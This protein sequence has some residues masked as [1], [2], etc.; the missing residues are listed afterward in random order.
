MAAPVSCVACRELPEEGILSR[1]LFFSPA[2]DLTTMASSTPTTT[3]PWTATRRPVFPALGLQPPP[4]RGD[5]GEAYGP[6]EAARWLAVSRFSSAILQLCQ[7]IAVSA[8]RHMAWAT[9]ILRVIW[10]SHTAVAERERA[11]L[12]QGPLAPDGLFGPRFSEVLAHQQSVRENRSRFG[13][14]LTRSSHQQAGR[15]RG[16]GRF[17]DSSPGAAA[18]AADWVAVG[19]R[20]HMA[21][22]SPASKKRRP[23]EPLVARARGY[24]RLYRSPSSPHYSVEAVGAEEYGLFLD[25]LPQLSARPLSD[26][27]ACWQER[28][29]TAL[30]TMRLLGLMAAAHPVVPLGLLFMRRLQRWFARQRCRVPPPAWVEYPVCLNSSYFIKLLDR[31]LSKAD[32]S[33]LE[34]MEVKKEMDDE[35]CGKPEGKAEELHGHTFSWM[36]GNENPYDV[37]CR[38]AGTIYESLQTSDAFKEMASKNQDKELVILRPNKKA[39]NSNFPCHKMTEGDT[40]TIK[41]IK[42]NS[43]RKIPTTPTSSKEKK[44]NE[45]ELVT[46]GIRTTGGKNLSRTN[47]MNNVGLGM[48]VDEISVCGYKGQTVREALK[49]DGRL[50]DT[51]LQNNHFLEETEVNKRTEMSS[52]I[53]FLDGRCFKIATTRKSVGTGKHD[54]PKEATSSKNA[55]SDIPTPNQPTPNTSLQ[56]TPNTIHQPTPSTSHQPTPTKSDQLNLEEIANLLRS[57]FPDLSKR[58]KKR[59]GAE[60]PDV[61]QLFSQEFGKNIAFCKK[62]KTMRKFLDLGDS[63]CQVR[64]NGNEIGSGFLLFGKYI[65]TNAHVVLDEEKINLRENLTVIFAYEDLIAN[66]SLPATVEAWTY[67]VDKDNYKEDWA[68]LEV[69]GDLNTLPKI[70]QPLLEHFGFVKKGGQICIIGHPEGKVKMIDPCCTVTREEF[71]K[72]NRPNLLD[73]IFRDIH[74]YKTSFYDGSSGS[75]VFDI[76]FKVVSMHTGGFKNKKEEQSIEYSHPLSGIIKQIIIKIVMKRKVH[77]LLAMI[78]C[79]IPPVLLAGIEEMDKYNSKFVWSREE[80]IYLTESFCEEDKERLHLF[81][82]FFSKRDEPMDTSS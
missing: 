44:E 20:V 14:I 40:L 64:T 75:P 15:R 33:L 62:A 3:P 50:C 16:P 71:E 56:P 76:N 21:S 65:L 22:G 17:Q 66:Q 6:E 82:R 12:V 79:G 24:G 70:P 78:T 30:S 63:V 48:I 73:F 19:R 43:K 5:H 67:L 80:I 61:R 32:R 55:S 4:S 52:I 28:N 29:V 35:Y 25:G 34:I 42:E 53:D 72:K 41:Y 1:H 68:L 45:G 39:I 49:Q 8:G 54:A 2:V 31:A 59:K 9:M 58:M 13:A 27:Y 18:A 36:F 60:S 7:P 10:L 37:F 69:C 46:F 47:V 51:V 74:T 26:R 81:F 11:S 38:K 23:L 77:V 57:Q